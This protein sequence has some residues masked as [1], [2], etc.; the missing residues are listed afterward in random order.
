MRDAWVDEVL[1][2]WFS[3][4]ETA[5]WFKKSDALDAQISARFGA[6]HTR[7]S[8]L[9]D[10][11]LLCDARTGL[12]AIIVFDQFSRNMFRGTAESF[13]CDARALS[14]ARQVV[15]RGWDTAMS[16]DERSFVYLPFEHSEDMDDQNRAVELMGALGREVLTKYALCPSRGHCEIW[17]V[18]ASQ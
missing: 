13:A 17:P 1:T 7:I 14:L 10:A 16:V 15:D 2:F 18:P 11:E 12:A 6:L 8:H 3:E 4:L 5:D 9:D